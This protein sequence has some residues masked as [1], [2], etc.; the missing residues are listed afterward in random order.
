MGLLDYANS[1]GE[2]I[3]KG[4]IKEYEAWDVVREH[5]KDVRVSEYN[6][7]CIQLSYGNETFFITYV[8]YE[9]DNEIV[10][11]IKDGEKLD[12]SDFDEGVLC[13]FFN[14]I[15]QLNN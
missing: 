4:L 3:D 14:M 8:E 7:Y 2:F 15:V 9:Y 1:T 11:I 13:T 5:I 12:T 10:S 6:T